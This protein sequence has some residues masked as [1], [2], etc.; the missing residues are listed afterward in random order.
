MNLYLDQDRNNIMLQCHV[1]GLGWCPMT[2]RELPL[3]FVVIAGECSGEEVALAA[4][5]AAALPY[6]G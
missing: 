1:F 3:G 2:T 6:A 4:T 5:T